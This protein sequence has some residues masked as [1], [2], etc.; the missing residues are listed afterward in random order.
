MRTVI[1]IE[2]ISRSQQLIGFAT[3]V[4]LAVLLARQDGVLAR[5][6]SFACAAG[7][8][9]SLARGLVRIDLQ[10]RVVTTGYQI[11][12]LVNLT[13][14]RIPLSSV[15]GILVWF[16]QDH[17]NVDVAVRT[18]AWHVE[19]VLDDEGYLLVREEETTRPG[20]KAARELASELAAR[21]GLPL[22]IV[23][24]ACDV[25]PAQDCGK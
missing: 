2:R 18:T 16:R 9:G 15:V 14:R 10:E 7:A 4:A 21:L 1:T 3:L 24:S 13:R 20:E 11:A 8:L 6:G 17:R 12:G 23:E 25:R 19:L 5:I 22:R